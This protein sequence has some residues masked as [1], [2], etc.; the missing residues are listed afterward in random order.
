[1][2]GDNGICLACADVDGDDE[3]MITDVTVI[4]DL[5]LKGH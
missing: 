5:L 1:M 2:G 3:V 4:I